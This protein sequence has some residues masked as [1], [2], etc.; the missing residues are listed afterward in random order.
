MANLDKVP[1]TGALIIVTWPSVEHGLGF[2]ARA[3]AIVP[4]LEPKPVR[5]EG[6]LARSAVARVSRS[7]LSGASLFSAFSRVNWSIT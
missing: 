4:L 5:Y 3:F 6:A 2:P 7:T 1:A